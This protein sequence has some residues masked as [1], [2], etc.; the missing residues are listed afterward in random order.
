ML[1]YRKGCRTHRGGCGEHVCMS[2][3]S[4]VAC[5]QP[6]LQPPTTAASH[7]ICHRRRHAINNVQPCSHP[8]LALPATHG[9]PRAAGARVLGVL[10]LPQAVLDALRGGRREGRYKRGW[11]QQQGLQWWWSVVPLQ[12]KH[13]CCC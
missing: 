3:V 4:L 10:A 12:S 5:S 1:W 9:A 13:Q 7:T 8:P 11:G 6:P 2:L